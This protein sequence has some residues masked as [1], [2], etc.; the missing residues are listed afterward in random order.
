MLHSVVSSCLGSFREGIL[1]QPLQ[2]VEAEQAEE[3]EGGTG[4]ATAIA[5]VYKGPS[6]GPLFA[7]CGRRLTNEPWTWLGVLDWEISGQLPYF[8]VREVLI[9]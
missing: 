2:E 6:Q 1:L 9:K 8:T 5:N 4:A 7:I 3:N